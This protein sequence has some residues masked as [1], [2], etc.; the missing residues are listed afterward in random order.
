MNA[1]GMMLRFLWRCLFFL[2]GFLT[3]IPLFPVFYFFLRKESG[4]RKAFLLK[5]FWAKLIVG[6][7]GLRCRVLRTPEL[8]PKQPYILCPNH[9]SYLDIVLMYRV[10]SHYFHFMGKAE[11]RKVP[12]FST[13]FN[14]MNIVVDRQSII[15]SHRAFNRAIQDID[16]GISVGIFPEA[17]IPESSPELGRFKN[18]AFKLAIEKQIPIVPVVFLDNWKLL[19]D[20]EGKRFKG[21][22]GV[23][24][25]VIHDPIE[26]KGMTAKDMVELR[27]RVFDLIRNTLV[28]YGMLPAE[29]P[30]MV[31]D[32]KG[33]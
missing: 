5:R 21:G 24:R 11:L 8:D 30:A 27:G 6:N 2:N 25:V 20:T 18:G 12:M 33:N 1:F 14:K 9:T 23:S 10:F 7:V 22:P 29:K 16:K 3:F 15:G 19:P 17:T 13:F 26:T 31:K 4:F 28:E 32:Y